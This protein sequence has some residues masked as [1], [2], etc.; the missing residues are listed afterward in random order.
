MAFEFGHF[1]RT[2]LKGMETLDEDFVDWLV[3]DWG[4][5]QMRR[6]EWLRDYYH[7]DF[8]ATL[9]DPAGDLNV[10]GLPYR[11]AQEAGLPRR[12]TGRV[13]GGENTDPKNRRKEVVIENDIAWRIDTIVDFLFGKPFQIIS[14]CPDPNRAQAMQ[15]IIE[16]VFS[17]NGGASYFQGLALLGS[18]Y[19]LVDVV[20]RWDRIGGGTG[21]GE[22]AGRQGRGASGPEQIEEALHAARSMILEAIEAPRCLPVLNTCDYTRIDYYIQ[23][24]WLEH[25]HMSDGASWLES[26]TAQ[27]RRVTPR[28]ETH[29]VEIL[30]PRWYQRY[31]DRILLDEG[32][33]PLGVV[34]V[35]HI[36]NMPLPLK[37]EG[38]SD[39]EPLIPLQ[40]E[41]NTRLSDRAN[42]IALQSFKM[43]LGKGIDGFVER[44]VGPGQMWSTLNTQASIEV[45]GGDSACP[46]ETEHIEQIREAMEKAS[47]VASVAAGILKGR[48]GNLTSAVA[49]KVTLMGVLA[50]T[51]RKRQSYGQGIKELCRLILLAMDKT[52]VFPN[53][54]SE[55]E[56]DILWPDPLPENKLEKL[57]EA[58]MKLEVG[59]G[60]DQ[61]LKELGY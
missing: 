16:A 59:V 56:F 28:R 58:K 10:G 21:R 43:Y 13:S 8:S 6:C 5:E 57:Q 53:D 9:W 4:V 61:V 23:H 22:V 37:Y 30:A 48:V 40:D 60:P 29:E 12:I 35:V 32:P 49:L 18:I 11:Q 54:E 52:G 2:Q 31:R 19:G 25:P 50:K 7:N 17:A 33:N 26:E 1:R 36:Q 20:L 51:E 46:S 3:H 55:R 44:Q 34:P 14:R 38:Q 24:Y 15:Q 42:R 47:G 45:F 41:L 27:G 39:V